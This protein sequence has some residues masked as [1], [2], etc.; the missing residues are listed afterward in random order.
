KLEPKIKHLEILG[1]KRYHSRHQ[2]YY[3]RKCP[4]IL[5]GDGTTAS[6]RWYYCLPPWYHH[7]ESAQRF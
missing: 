2:R 7:R 4:E 3:C 6:H 5:G 1:Y